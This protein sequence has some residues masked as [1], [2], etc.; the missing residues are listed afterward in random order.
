MSGIQP[1][2]RHTLTHPQQ[3]L[4]SCIACQWFFCP[5]ASYSSTG[6]LQLGGKQDP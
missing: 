4:N 5:S 3:L 6:I 1:E 2:S